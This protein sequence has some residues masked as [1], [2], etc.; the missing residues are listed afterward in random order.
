MRTPLLILMMNGKACGAPLA[1]PGAILVAGALGGTRCSLCGAPLAAPGVVAR[2]A[3]CTSSRTSTRQASPFPGGYVPR[4]AVG[5]DHSAYL[6]SLFELHANEAR[7]CRKLW[8]KEHGK[9]V[10][11]CRVWT[12]PRFFDTY[13]RLHDLHT[14]YTYYAS[15]DVA[16]SKMKRSKKNKGFHEFATS[17]RIYI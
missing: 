9:W 12:L 5:D 6:K 15:L 4:H 2:T 13:G 10:H 3:S 11:T 17:G 16:I 7:S 14:I 8:V 1:A